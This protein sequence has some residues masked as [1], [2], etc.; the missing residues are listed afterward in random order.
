MKKIIP[1][2]LIVYSLLACAPTESDI[3]HML[4][5][6]QSAEVGRILFQQYSEKADEVF[7]RN[8]IIGEF[9][10]KLQFDREENGIY[11]YDFII[12]PSSQVMICSIVEI[13][14]P[15]DSFDATG[16][17]KKQYKI[18]PKVIFSNNEY[19]LASGQVYRNG[20]SYSISSFSSGCSSTTSDSVY[21]TPV[22]SSITSDTTSTEK[23]LGRWKD[24]GS[25]FNQTIIIK[26]SGDDYIM[27]EEYSDGSGQTITLE[28]EI[29]N[30]ETRLYDMKNAFGDYMVI[31]GN[32][33]L[34]FYDNQG[35]IYSIE[36]LSGSSQNQTNENNNSSYSSSSSSSSSTCDVLWDNLIL[37]YEISGGEDTALTKFYMEEMLKNN[38][39]PK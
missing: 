36:P 19:H 12:K 3:Q 26:R 38:C 20:K 30:G 8:N 2:F 27:T 24:T 28:V 33:N 29:V 11:F 16:I 9:E 5:H 37:A 31:K 21:K 1:F 34:S 22:S 14:N 4:A 25:G 35:F 7:A 15:L 18:T 17:D 6:T 39:P 10:Y 32:G 13:L 23:I